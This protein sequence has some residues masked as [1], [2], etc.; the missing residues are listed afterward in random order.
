M[1]RKALIGNALL[2]LTA[3]SGPPSPAEKND[4]SSKDFFSIAEKEKSTVSNI[5]LKQKP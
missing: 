1:N 5:V 4:R 3:S 2:L